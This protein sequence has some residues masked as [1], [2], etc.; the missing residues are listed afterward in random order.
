MLV[1]LSWSNAILILAA[2]ILHDVHIMQTSP[3]PCLVKSYKQ[4][5]NPYLFLPVPS[6]SRV[7]QFLDLTRLGEGDH[8]VLGI[9]A[10][11]TT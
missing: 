7:K 6:L 2:I 9:K 3:S 10:Y 11:V 8:I 4:S 5:T 1:L